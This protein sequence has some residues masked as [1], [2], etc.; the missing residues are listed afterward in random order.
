MP[1]EVQALRAPWPSLCPDVTGLTEELECDFRF[2]QRVSKTELG[3]VMGGTLK[4]GSSSVWYPATQEQYHAYRRWQR[5]EGVVEARDDAALESLQD[6][7]ARHDVELS[8]RRGRRAALRSPQPSEGPPFGGF[9]PI[10]RDMAAILAQ[11]PAEHLARPTLERIHLGGWGP[12]AAKASAYQ[13]GAVLMYDFACRG[14]RRT[15][16]GLFLHELGHAHEAALDE[17]ARDVLHRAYEVLLEE[18]A[19]FG[20]E[21]LLD[22]ETRRIYQ[23]FVFNEF[24]AET[25]LVYTA[26]GGRM[27]D[28]IAAWPP[29]ARAAWDQVYAL[30]RDS[31]AGVEYE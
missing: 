10:Y 25:Y 27:R 15:F 23:R 20:V 6:L 24:L 21:F 16:L 22:A 18:D 19:F 4:G 13:D 29:R 14:A 1:P 12:D 7:L 8:T 11:L 3:Y 28:G 31:F 5:R 2:G 30:F 26:C 9:G 17:A